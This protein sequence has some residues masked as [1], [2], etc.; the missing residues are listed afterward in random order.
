MPK[1]KS[2]AANAVDLLKADHDK[3][4]KAFKEFQKMDRDDGE[5]CRELVSRVCDDLRMHTTL[6]EE[7]FYPAVREAIDDD[8]IMNEAA[9]EH[10]T[11]KMLIEQLENMEPDDPNYFATFTVLGEYVTHHVKEEE[12]EMF[13]QAQ[14]AKELDLEALREQ[15][16]SR[17]EELMAEMAQA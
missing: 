17:K 16:G 14:K 3:V 4:K 10:E 13:P 15:M 5:A 11:A 9:V 2:K 8:D 1:S 6:E 12:D 7:I